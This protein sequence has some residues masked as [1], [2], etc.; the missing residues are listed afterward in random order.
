MKVL[1]GKGFGGLWRALTAELLQALY[2]T[3]PEYFGTPFEV[4]KDNWPYVNQPEVGLIITPDNMV[5]H[6]DASIDNKHAIELRVNIDVQALFEQ[7]GRKEFFAIIDVPDG[8]DWDLQMNEYNSVEMVV[9][10]HQ[11]WTA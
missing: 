5:Q 1:I 4:T 2:K 7:Y 9:E 3:H 10:K 8:V 11:I 6:F